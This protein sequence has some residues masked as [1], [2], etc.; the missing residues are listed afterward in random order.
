MGRRTGPSARVIVGILAAIG[1]RS[2]LGLIAGLAAGILFPGLAAGLR[3]HLTALIVALLFMA[4]LRVEPRALVSLRQAALHDVPVVLALQLALP[5]L[6]GLG[7]W[8][9][10]WTGQLPTMLAL[11]AAASPITGTPAIA[12]LM[13]Q[14]GAVGLRLLLWGTLLLPITSF[15]PLRLLFGEGS[16]VDVAGSSLR[17]AAIVLVCV[18]GGALVRRSLLPSLSPRADLALGGA[19]T[20]LLAVFVIALMDAVQP[21]LLA[22]PFALAGILAAACA[23][24]FALQA[25]A[26]LLYRGLVGARQEPGA[27]GAVGVAAGNRNIA[28]FLAALPAAQTDPLMVLVGCYQ[29]PMYL[30]PV[31]MRPLYRSLSPA[32]SAGRLGRT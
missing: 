26:A 10:G 24:C 7:L 28:L 32:A 23:M 31:L 27:A 21:A 12:Q 30:T 20:V 22:A 15:V 17:L 29:I 11:L 2:Q 8:G 9:S 4:S 3:A 5:L 6:V 14:S 18:A 13:G 16:G 25:A 1:R 19:S